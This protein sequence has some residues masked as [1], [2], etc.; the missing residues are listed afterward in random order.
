MLMAPMK[1]GKIDTRY[2]RTHDVLEYAKMWKEDDVWKI[3]SVKTH[4]VHTVKRVDGAWKCTC[5]DCRIRRIMCKHIM[6]VIV[7]EKEPDWNLRR[8]RGTAIHN[9]NYI[10]KGINQYA[11]NANEI[12]CRICKRLYELEIIQRL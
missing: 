6:A 11:E 10:N 1:D 2:R 5:Q 3:R 8:H 4:S 9:P 12:T 7:K